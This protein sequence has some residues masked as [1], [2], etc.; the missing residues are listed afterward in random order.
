MNS[1]MEFYYIW[2][3]NYLSQYL[4]C[5]DSKVVINYELKR[6]H[7]YRVRDNI[8]KI[9][10][11]LNLDKNNLKLCEIIGLF[12]DVG[13]FKQ[14]YD[15]GTFSD[16][17]TGSHGKISIN[18]LI[19]CD[20]LKNLKE[21]EKDIVLKSI[22][23]HN[24][25]YIPKSESEDIKFFSR[26]IRDADKLDAFYLETDKN[27]DRRY[28]LEELSCEKEYSEEIIRDIMESRQV[29]FKNIKYKYDRKLAILGLIFDLCYNQSYEIFE[30]ER[31][32]SRIFKDL[33]EDIEIERIFSHCNNHIKCKLNSM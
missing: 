26:L 29:D 23:Y 5:K 15:Y 21:D 31:Y 20:V 14:Y 30:S 16:A 12:H 32:L 11:K 13:R 9:G 18:V 33:P 27:E 19:E 25:L 6:E 24:C 10:E 17:I 28:D 1:E 8:L 7:T 22:D 2:F 4:S 3:E